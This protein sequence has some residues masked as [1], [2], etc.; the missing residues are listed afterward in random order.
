MRYFRGQGCSLAES[1][2]WSTPVAC[3]IWNCCRI[4]FL[5]SEDYLS[6]FASGTSQFES[7]PAAIAQTVVYTD[8]TDRITAHLACIMALTPSRVPVLRALPIFHVRI[9]QA[10]TR[11]SPANRLGSGSRTCPVMRDNLTQIHPYDL[12]GFRLLGIRACRP[13]NSSGW[14]SRPR[15]PAL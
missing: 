5:R 7:V 8:H 15:A 12:A 2:L 13:N 14:S 4:T 10:I 11:C 1:G 6:Q 3:N 9:S